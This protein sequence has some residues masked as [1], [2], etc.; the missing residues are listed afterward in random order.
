MNEDWEN[1]HNRKKQQIRGKKTQQNVRQI[2]DGRKIW[3]GGEQ[4]RCWELDLRKDP[5]VLACGLVR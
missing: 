5:R 1:F 2:E 4:A 3:E